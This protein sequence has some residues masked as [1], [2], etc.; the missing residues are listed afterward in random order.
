MPDQLA[1]FRDDL[2]HGFVRFATI[3][4]SL[5]PKPKP[6]DRIVLGAVK[7]KW[8]EFQPWRFS[9]KCLHFLAPVDAAIIQNQ[10]QQLIRKTL[11]QLMQ[12]SDKR[13]GIATR[14]LFPI[15]PLTMKV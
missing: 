13:T 10:H 14:G 3:D 12:E 1:D 6:L 4:F 2:V 5:E 9:Y 8:L 7:R 15:H 11:V